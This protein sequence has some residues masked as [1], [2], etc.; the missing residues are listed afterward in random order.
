MKK[1]TLLVPLLAALGISAAPAMGADQELNIYSARHYQTDE[2][3]YGEF[4]RQTGIKV[5]RI[6]AKEAELIERIKNE[7]EN[8]PADIFITVDASRLGNADSMGLFAPFQ[9]DVIDERVPAHFRTDTW[10]AFSTRARVIIYNPDLVKAEDVQTYES[11]ADPK[12]KGKVCTRTGAHPYNLS[13][14]AALIHH[15]GAEKT[16]EWAEGIVANFARSPRGGDTDQIRA[17]AAGECGV[18]IANSYYFA[19]LM[20]SDRE[21][22]KQVVESVKFVW[23]NQ[24]SWGTHVN[25]SGAGVLKHA[26]NKAAAKK[27]LEYLTSDAA[28]RYFANGNNEWP[29]VPSVKFE[30]HALDTLGSFKAD[31]MPVAELAKNVPEAQK[32]FDRAGYR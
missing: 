5:N 2:Q 30:N 16:E 4:T 18:A 25:V 11:L 19:R 26:P 31:D 8:S 15:H 27:F 21:Q 13:L 23:P 20:N 10:V 22:D 3:L 29:T 7:G 17:V 24:D 12:L 28:Q 1:R 9:S 32:I 6:E 14:G